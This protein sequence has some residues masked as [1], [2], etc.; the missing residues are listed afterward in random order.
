MVQLDHM[1]VRDI[2]EDGLYKSQR[3]V[4]PLRPAHIVH[5]RVI[6]DDD[7]GMYIKPR[8]RDA[9]RPFLS[10]TTVDI[11]GA[12]TTFQQ[13]VPV[14]GIA[15]EDRRHYR[16]T[17]FIDDIK[18][19]HAGSAK[20]GLAN[21][22]MTNPVERD[23][24]LLEGRKHSAEELAVGKNWYNAAAAVLQ[25]E[26]GEAAAT[27]ALGQSGVSQGIGP[28]LTY[29]KRILD[30]R[31]AELARLRGQVDTMKKEREI[32]SLTAQIGEV[33]AEGEGMRMGGTGTMGASA[34]A[35]PFENSAGNMLYRRSHVIA[36]ESSLPLDPS[37]AFS[38]PSGITSLTQD[39]G[40]YA[41]GIAPPP[42]APLAGTARN[43]G[44]GAVREIE[45]ASTSS[46]AG[47][48]RLSATGGDENL[49]GTSRG[50]LPLSTYAQPGS[51]AYDPVAS[52][53]SSVAAAQAKNIIG[54]IPAFP[55]ATIRAAMGGSGALRTTG[56]FDRVLESTPLTVEQE[57]R[58]VKHRFD[59]P[60]P[61]QQMPA[62]VR[63]NHQ[64]SIHRQI[65]RDKAAEVA[66]VHSLP[67][68]KRR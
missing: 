18:G 12:Q 16:V 6:H 29:S 32:M 36:P 45:S 24:I 17:N 63:T 51:Y 35:N 62:L 52:L 23:Y 21:A 7:K 58:G 10:L 44:P 60:P 30:P 64:A 68:A 39:K 42:L 9:G 1:Q 40:S 33:R 57:Q 59:R 19:A 20:R 55:S 46:R 34:R 41:Y 53:R 28:A 22:R 8:T 26:A 4:D 66:D 5:G 37:P 61:S 38:A 25:A 50:A 56:H 67:D 14:G 31:D 54:V 15:P 2:N 65:M 48:A 27:M 3:R 49:H 11:E 13:E 43:F 47:S